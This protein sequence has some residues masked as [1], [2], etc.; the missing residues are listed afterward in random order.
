M[1]SRLA[2][3]IAPTVLI[4]VWALL[5]ATVFAGYEF[6]PSPTEVATALVDLIGSGD[7][8]RAVAH[9]LRMSLAATAIAVIVGGLVGAGIGLLEPV[10][11]YLMASIDFL[12]TIP[13]VAM[14]P[15]AL[16][17]LGPIGPTELLLASF[18]ATWPV[19]ITTAAGVA[20]A[21]PRHH[22]VA[23]TFRLS[24]GETFRKVVVPAAVPAWLVGA[25]LAA[26]IGLLASIVAE[27]LMY[28][29]GLGGGLIEAFHALAPARMWAFVLVCGLL[30]VLMNAALRIAVRLALPGSPAV[31]GSASRASVA[32]VGGVAT[33]PTGLLPLVAVFVVWQLSAPAESLSFPPPSEW[34]AALGRLCR[35]GTLATAIANT[36]VSYVLGL[37]LATLVGTALGTTIGASRTADRSLTGT[38]DFIAAIPAAALVP[39]AALVFGPTHTAGVL[40]VGL[41]ASLP[42][43]LSA[44]TAMRSVPTVRLEM[45]RSIGLSPLQRWTK[46]VAPSLLPGVLLGVRVAASVA[47]IVTLLVDVFGTGTGVGRLL[48]LS[49]QHFDAAAAWGLLLI[50]G[51]FGYL[52]S[53]VLNHTPRLTSSATAPGRT[54]A[55]APSGRARRC[56]PS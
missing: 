22:D 14:V 40:V 19:V 55:A 44:A 9:T 17:A 53:V 47:I 11:Q 43:T 5:S 2:T 32:P 29:R 12:R 37:A 54:A 45:S 38:L 51:G 26:V 18:A 35:E 15:V 41:V 48:V 3:L 10:R 30:G 36:L 34:F 20:S 25:R 7:M 49:Q 21:H 23:R 52:S 39:L 8:S 6:I 4:V 13:A 33:P 24:H 28:P 46:V 56:R 31:G 16:L 27:M 50:V 1:G 42:I